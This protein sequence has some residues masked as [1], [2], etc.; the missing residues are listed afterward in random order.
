[1][2][3]NLE[4]VIK[5][6]DQSGGVLDK[7]GKKVG[8]I[9]SKLGGAVKAGAAV[10][11][12]AL[13][14]V[15]TAA[16]TSAL[17]FE[18]SFAEVA[19]LL[20][21]LDEKGIGELRKGV[22]D[23]SNE[24][25]IATSDAVPA[26]YQAI[27]AGV[28]PSNVLS[29]MET[30]AGASIGGVT[31]LETAVDGISTVVNTYGSEVIS[32]QE[33]SD[34]MFTTVK[35]GKTDFGQLSSSLFNVLPVAS[36]LGIGFDEVA[37]AMATL[38]AQGVPTSVATTQLRAAFVEASKGG[39]NLDDAIRL[40]Y[41]KKGLGQLVSEGITATE[42][43]Y[44]LRE[45]M[46]EQEFKDLFGSVEAGQAV[47]GITGKNFETVQDTMDE[48]ADS[49]GATERAFGVMADTTGYKLDR[50][51]NRVNNLL[52]KLGLVILP[53]LEDAL[54]AAIPWLEKNLP[55]ALDALKEGFNDAKPFL[56][57]FIEG[58]EILFPLSKDVVNFIINHKPVLIAALVAIGLAVALAFGPAGVATLAIIAF[59]AILPQLPEAWE[60][61]KEALSENWREIL[62]LVLIL[63]TGPGGL[64]FLFVSNSFGIR[65]KVIEIFGE[66]KAF[67]LRIPGELLWAMGDVLGLLWWKGRDLMQGLFNGVVIAF[68]KVKAFFLGLPDR[69]ITAIGDLTS[70]LYQ[71]G[72]DLVKGLVKGMLSVAIPN[73]LDL[74]KQG[75][76]GLLGGLGDT[77]GSLAG[78]GRSP[79][80]AA[81]R[82][83]GGFS[84]PKFKLAETPMT[85]KDMKKILGVTSSVTPGVTS[86]MNPFKTSSIDSCSKAARCMDPCSGTAGAVKSTADALKAAEAL[87]ASNALRFDDSVFEAALRA[88]GLEIGL[89]QLKTAEALKA[90]DDILRSLESGQDK[91]AE[92]ARKAETLRFWKTTQDTRAR[93]IGSPYYRGPGGGG[94]GSLV[95]NF[96]GPLAGDAADADIFA[97]RLQDRLLRAGRYRR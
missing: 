22:I 51:M 74:V 59:I 24:L 33:A 11:A 78:F 10:G 30:A 46:P 52:L 17:R 9:G 91:A 7:V 84:L 49:A 96:N 31:D 68:D 69:I 95:V 25:G 62:S 3:A 88:K 76:G 57:S 85:A 83:L 55:K 4:I 2:A 89:G 16:V 56:E 40:L 28:P 21:D 35:L 47:L 45:S 12:V 14:G 20:P 70:K 23:F 41:G 63:F 19:T 18:K 80:G 29:F 44:H 81:G 37:A 48:M 73:P 15:G 34:L 67:F 26:L 87:K 71:K 61:V 27:S 36:S 92:A 77:I 72:V 58:L 43:F 79:Q 93:E 53:I 50:A 5:A 86:S 97:E 60:R 75:A 32:A 8:A 64:I 65:D 13:A 66:I 90:V 38:T 6:I 42:V 94:A 82:G 54:E 39:S 1:M